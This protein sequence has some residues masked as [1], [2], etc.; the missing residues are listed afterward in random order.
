M[1]EVRERS[2]AAFVAESDERRALRRA[3][4]HV[5]AA[6]DEVARRVARAEREL[7]GRERRLRP[8][9]ARVEADHAVVRN[10][11]AG[12]AEGLEC[13]GMVELDADL[14]GEALGTRLDRG[15]SVRRKR[16]EPG[17]PVDEHDGSECRP[18]ANDA[19]LELHMPQL[20][21]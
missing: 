10:R 14:G 8:Q 12:L 19:Q 2:V 16:L 4:D 6:D 17:H 1:L 18:G 7:R 15:E 20:A 3:E 11:L 5:V 9:E 13:G 21:A